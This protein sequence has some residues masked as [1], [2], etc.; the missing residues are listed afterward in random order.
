ML[1]VVEVSRH[2]WALAT[3]FVVCAA[4]A[5]QVQRYYKW[6]DAQGVTH[7]G[8]TAPPGVAA[9]PVDVR[10]GGI[11]TTPAPASASTT[12]TSDTALQK[13]EAGARAQNCERARDNLRVL[14]G[15]AML[16]DSGDPTQ[17]RRLSPE[18]LERMRRRSN[19]EIA[20][21]CGASP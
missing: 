13:A 17:A 21:Y 20:E 5:Q 12:G 1:G 4:Q 16:V 8:D 2:A 3:F 11:E 15:K 18:D 6:T 10:G 7:Y 19:D 14:D 9:Q